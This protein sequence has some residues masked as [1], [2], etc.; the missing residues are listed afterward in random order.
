MFRPAPDENFRA[1]TALLEG[2]KFE[3]NDKILLEQ[4]IDVSKK[5]DELIVKRIGM[6]ESLSSDGFQCVSI[7]VGYM[8]HLMR[9]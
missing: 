3:G 4:I 9:C 7:Y 2:K 1:L 8:S 5:L 6:N